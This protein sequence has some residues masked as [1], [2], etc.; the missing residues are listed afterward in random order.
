[1]PATYDYLNLPAETNFRFQSPNKGTSNKI[2]REC[3]FIHFCP[4]LS[5]GN[6]KGRLNTIRP[7]KTINP[8]AEKKYCR[9]LINSGMFLTRFK[10]HRDE[11]EWEQVLI[12]TNFNCNERCIFCWVPPH[13][14]NLPHKLLEGVLKEILSETISNLAIVFTGG[15]P[16]LNPHLPDYIKMVTDAGVGSVELQTNALKLADTE[17]ARLLVQN[18]LNLALISLHGHTPELSDRITRTP[19]AFIKTVAGA[20]N[21]TDF[22]AAVNFNFVMNTENYPA[23][24]SYLDFIKSNFPQSSVIL[25]IIGPKYALDLYRNV[26]PRLSEQAP[27]VIDG[28][29]ILGDK[30][31][32]L[33]STCGMPPCVLT[34]GIELFVKELIPVTLDDGLRRIFHK[35]KTCDSCAT[36]DFCFGFWRNYVEVYGD[37]EMNPIPDSPMIR[38]RK[39]M[40]KIQSQS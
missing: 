1:M 13:L 25:S 20:K 9:K 17:Y 37:D 30:L 38:K 39:E 22:G 8:E 10:F 2:C 23:I 29:K 27:Y 12:R 26:L 4:G 18:G 40:F 16:T 3:A 15:E 34:D 36:N 14:G 35:K 24:P 19:G 33:N 28:K 6:L 5:K 32:V 11:L 21:L 7:F 31:V